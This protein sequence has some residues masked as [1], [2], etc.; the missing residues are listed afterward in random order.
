[1]C[2]IT[3][4]YC[5]SNRAEVWKE[6]VQLS[7]KK[8]FYRGPDSNGLFIHNKIALGHSRLAII[9]TSTAAAQPFSDTSGRYTI[10]FNGEIFNFRELKVDLLKKG[11]NF[12]SNSDTEVLLH[13]YINEGTDFLN[14]LNGFFVFCIYDKEKDTVFIARDRYGI[15]PLFYYKDDNIFIFASE[16][17]AILEYGI[18]KELDYASLF[19]FLQLSYIPA[20]DS[21]F[22]DIKKIAAGHYFFIEN[23]N[24]SEHIYYSIP[25]NDNI[26]LSN[27]PPSYENAKDKIYN[28]L[29]ASVKRRLISDVPLGAFLSGGIDSSIIVALASKYTSQLNTFS[30]GF[31]DEPFFDETRYARLVANKYKTNH[32][33]FKLSNSDLY[34][35]LFK[36]LDYTDE[37]FADSSAIAVYI[38]SGLTRQ[39]VT[40]ALSG[41]GADELFGGYNKYYAEYQFRNS[42]LSTK[43]IS[44]LAPLWKAF[45]QSRNSFLSNK[46]RQLNRFAEGAKMSY[47]DRY[48]RW[49]SYIN[50]DELRALIN[51]SHYLN[52]KDLKD[53]KEELTKHIKKQKSLNDVLYSDLHLVLSN[54]MLVKADLMSM[55]NSLE[56]RV[57]FL[58]F[59][60]V[61]YVSCLPSEYKIDKNNRKKILKD[62]FSDYLSQELLNR[63]KHGFEVP[64]LSWFRNE[65]KSHIENK[66]LN[67]NLIIKQNIFNPDETDLLLK[68]LNSSNP[69]DIG[70]RIWT[71]VVFQY[72]WNKYFN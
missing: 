30:I 70:A 15:K 19:S 42:A 14:K 49:C 52:I 64:L 35:V 8:L 34:D 36:V 4:I 44:A 23:N 31:K 56:I 29:D 66:V 13:L 68:K 71:L 7:I 37:P 60:L 57:P 2:G 16:I 62:T 26:F 72:W 46:A 3:G 32:T 1:M 54:D 45:P 61:N 59:E 63:R 65:L 53:R 21:I 33:E 43:I 51:S 27:P 41:D 58:D 48:W 10:V 50:D 25:K 18:R 38:L 6:K 55:A 47:P 20:P 24:I 39:Y 28:L 12:T 22:K 67:R 11:I 40:V 9:D 69:G 17:K 5:F